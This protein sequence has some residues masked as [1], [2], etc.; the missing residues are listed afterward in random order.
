[1]ITTYAHTMS[2]LAP[3]WCRRV[4][5][6][7]QPVPHFLNYQPAF[8]KIRLLKLTRRT[9]AYFMSARD[10]YTIEDS[11]PERERARRVAR[12][13]RKL[14]RSPHE[15]GVQGSH[16]LATAFG[17]SEHGS[18]SHKGEARLLSYTPIYCLTF[19]PLLRCPK[20]HN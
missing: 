3:F 1:M 7:I 5:R 9:L 4:A 8:S 19:D 2:Q 10:D 18:L 12:E 20:G 16:I 11:E 17:E 14:E 13:T 15:R 6:T